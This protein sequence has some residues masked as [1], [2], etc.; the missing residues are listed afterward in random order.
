MESKTGIQRAVDQFDGSPTKL[1]DAVGNEVSRQN[2]E[3]WLKA[4]RVPMEKCAAVAEVV[5]GIT[6][7]DL[8][9]RVNWD[10]VRK[11]LRKKPEQA[12]A[13]EQGA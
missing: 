1:A 11:L 3:T 9:D 8:N 12:A 13:V 5:T 2:V 7:Q 6:L 10:K 4:G